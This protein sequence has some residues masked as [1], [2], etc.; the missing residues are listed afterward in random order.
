[1]HHHGHH[2][3]H[4]HGHHHHIGTPGVSDMRKDQYI[5]GLYFNPPSLDAKGH[6]EK[7]AVDYKQKF[8]GQLK[9]LRDKHLIH[10]DR[11][12][13]K[14]KEE[15]DQMTQ[16]QHE[17]KDR[18]IQDQLLHQQQ[19]KARLDHKQVH[20]QTRVMRSHES[21]Q[22]QQVGHLKSTQEAERQKLHDK[23]AH[24][25]EE[26]KGRQERDQLTFKHQQEAQFRRQQRQQI[27]LH[28]RQQNGTSK[29][30]HGLD[31]RQRSKR[32]ELLAHQ[33]DEQKRQASKQSND[34]LHLQRHQQR[35]HPELFAPKP[36]SQQAVYTPTILGRI[37]GMFGLNN[38]NSTAAGGQSSVVQA[39][40]Q[41]VQ[42]PANSGPARIPVPATVSTLQAVGGQPIHGLKT[43]ALLL[44][45]IPSTTTTTALPMTT[46]VAPA[47][48]GS[49]AAPAP[50]IAVV[51][52]PSA[53]PTSNSL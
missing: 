4:R 21:K 3:H 25:I 50:A 10:R 33:K 49:S 31:S 9:K 42:S 51:P 8:D 38:L 15:R 28:Q 47:P 13:S 16:R 52:A 7:K 46:T 27:Q 32:E 23:Q 39:A 29:Q 6:K 5:N 11:L 14:Q 36:Q 53:A 18:L 24:Q 19:Q 45:P 48:Q 40:Q 35:K 20:Q 43:A 2:H 30:L 37:S 12:L 34:V 26:L 17:K 44:K 22:Q 41:V 1:M